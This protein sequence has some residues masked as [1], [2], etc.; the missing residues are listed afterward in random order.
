VLDEPTIGL[1]PRQIIEIR[2]LIKSLSGERTVILSTHILPEVTMICSR[3]TIIDEGKIVLEESLDKI[4]E[5]VGTVQNLFLKINYK[6]GD[7]KE[8]ILSLQAVSDVDENSAGEFIVKSKD[9]EDIR[10]ELA[11]IV[12][13]NGWGLLEMRPLTHTLEE[14]FLRVIST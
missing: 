14:V 2:E 4:S 11:K 13:E 12:V 8:K 10:E 6:G 7:V 1:D 5:K 3:V 9:G